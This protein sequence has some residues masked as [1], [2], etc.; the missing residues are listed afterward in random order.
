VSGWTC[1]RCKRQFGRTNQSHGCAPAVAED[2]YFATAKPFERPMFEAVAAA[3]VDLEPLLIDFVDVG[4][5]FKRVRTFAELR[6]MRDRVRLAVLLSR[7]VRD[8][9]VVKTLRLSGQRSAIYVDLRGAEDVDETVREWLLES[10]AAS[11]T[12][13]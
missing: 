12:E 7:E 13:R 8:A 1:P 11:P 5:F 10:Y 9:R 4:I 6:P 2:E 3:L